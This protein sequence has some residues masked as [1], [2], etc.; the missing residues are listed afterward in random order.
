MDF[1]KIIY[2]FPRNS[3]IKA[4]KLVEWGTTARRMKYQRKSEF[5]GKKIMWFLSKCL[6]D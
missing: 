1:L 2:N 6:E 4:Q 5:G 3:Q